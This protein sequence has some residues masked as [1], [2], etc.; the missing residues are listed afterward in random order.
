MRLYIEPNYSPPVIQ[1]IQSLHQLEYQPKYE[2]VSGKWDNEYSPDDTAVFL[3]D[4]NKRG[5]STL[6]LDQFKDGYKVVAYKKPEG[7][8]FD[9]YDCALTMLSQWKKILSEFSVA[10]NKPILISISNGERPFRVIT[11]TTI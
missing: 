8:E 5:M 4:T 3:I 2:V 9:A 10:T 6:T 7:Q 11:P 1:L